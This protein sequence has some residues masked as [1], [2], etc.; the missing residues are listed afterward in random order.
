MDL[1][2][3]AREREL[4]T[5][6]DVDTPLDWSPDGA[7]IVCQRSGATGVD[8]SLMTVATGRTESL[9]LNTSFSESRARLSPD[10]R[11]IAYA[12]DETG[13]NEV[14]VAECPSGRGKRAVS[15]GGGDFPQWRA[16]GRELFYVSDLQTMMAVSVTTT[17]R[18][19]EVGPPAELFQIDRPAE[20]SGRPEASLYRVD[21]TGQRFLIAVRAPASSAPPIQVIV[22]WPALLEQR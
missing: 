1:D 19:P 3:G 13:R 9:T 15:T 21:A 2:S 5:G 12:S 20:V 8:L 16:D 6:P 7:T 14:F 10:G 18:G 4:T 17:A 11:W 22:N